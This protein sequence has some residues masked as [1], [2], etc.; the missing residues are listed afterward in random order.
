MMAAV[1][2]GA[3]G[4]SLS[5]AYFSR[6]KRKGRIQAIAGTTLGL[7]LLCFG[8]CAGLRVFPLAL[9]ALFFVG[10]SNDFYSTI[11]NTLIMLNTDRALYGRVMSAYMMTWSLSSLSS[12]PFGALMDHV[13]GAPTM[14]LIGVTL[15]VFVLGM[16]TLHPGYRRLT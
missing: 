15:S 6:S 5:M 4:G 16:A 3:L 10:M 8:L 12:A 14:L 9:L 11:N 2:I 1:G 7:S 13:G